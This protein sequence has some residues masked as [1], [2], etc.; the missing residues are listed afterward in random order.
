MRLALAQMTKTDSGYSIKYP[1]AVRQERPMPTSIVAMDDAQ[2]EVMAEMQLATADNDEWNQKEREK[3]RDEIC[4]RLREIRAKF[5]SQTQPVWTIEM[6]EWSVPYSPTLGM[7]WENIK[8]ILEEADRAH[9]DLMKL[10]RS[11]TQFVGPLQPIALIPPGPP[12]YG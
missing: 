2:I 8:K 1:E 3:R 7:P 6:R 10:M 5:T 12:S 11:G 4:S 9:E